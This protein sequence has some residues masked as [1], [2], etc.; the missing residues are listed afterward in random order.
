MGRPIGNPSPGKATLM[1]TTTAHRDHNALR[2]I[3]SLWIAPPPVDCPK[4]RIA[5]DL[6]K[7]NTPVD[8]RRDVAEM[9]VAIA[10]EPKFNHDGWACVA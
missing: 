4:A 7:W 1:P 9:M 2:L 5:A 6:G 8:D 10:K 3:A